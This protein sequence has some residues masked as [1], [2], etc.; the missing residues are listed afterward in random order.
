MFPQAYN[1]S[2]ATWFSD[3]TG[4]T[5]T[6]SSFAEATDSAVALLLREAYGGD[7]SSLDAITGALAEPAEASAG[8]FFGPLLHAA[9]TEQMYRC[10]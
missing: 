3:V 2:E 5:A 8:G 10:G 7:I 6:I 1:L 4:S 9:W